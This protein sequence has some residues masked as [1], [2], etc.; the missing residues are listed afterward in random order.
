LLIAGFSYRLQVRPD[1]D[2]ECILFE[3]EST[4]PPSNSSYNLHTYNTILQKQYL[5]IQIDLH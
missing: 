3:D 5:N 1:A 4:Y 2:A